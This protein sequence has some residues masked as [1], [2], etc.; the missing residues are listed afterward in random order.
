MNIIEALEKLIELGVKQKTL[1][2]YCGLVPGKITEI[3]KR[4]T[5]VD[6]DLSQQIFFGIN[7]YL[8]E[9]NQIKIEEETP[10]INNW[11]VYIHTFPNDK[12]YV[13][14]SMAPKN[15]WKNDGSGY[16]E[17]KRM[18][19][20]IQEFGWDNIKHEIILQDL[21]KETAREMEKILINQYKTMIPALG[22]NNNC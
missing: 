1:E 7:A 17:Q 19:E 18:W 21:S 5:K 3:I 22:Y 15:R 10:Q 13:G 6:K 8:E 9:L 11:S 4:R 16:K 20:A 12:K 14:I 2:T